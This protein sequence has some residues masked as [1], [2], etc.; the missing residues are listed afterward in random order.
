MK[1]KFGGFLRSNLAVFQFSKTCENQFG[2]P[3]PPLFG[4]YP[5]ERVF[6]SGL[7]LLIV[8]KKLLVTEMSFSGEMSSDLEIAVQY[9]DFILRWVRISDAHTSNSYTAQY[10]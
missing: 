1:V 10:S 8:M 2:Q 5:K 4:L 3:P 9:V 6:F 7:S